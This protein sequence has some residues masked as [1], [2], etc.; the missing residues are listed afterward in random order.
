MNNRQANFVATMIP[1]LVGALRHYKTKY[2]KD[3]LAL[4]TARVCDEMQ[5]DR[6]HF[7]KL[8]IA[9]PRKQKTK[10]KE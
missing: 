5:I 10:E 1:L 3:L 9:E 2:A 4:V 7:C 6:E 8:V